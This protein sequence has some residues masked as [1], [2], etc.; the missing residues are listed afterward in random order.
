VLADA[1]IEILPPARDQLDGPEAS[2]CLCCGRRGAIDD[3]CC[4]ICDD[5]LAL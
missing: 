2:T 3:D 1:L 5:C 4:R